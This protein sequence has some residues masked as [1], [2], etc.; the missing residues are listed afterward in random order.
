M[1]CLAPRKHGSS[2]SL[3]VELLSE[4]AGDSPTSPPHCEIPAQCLA[5]GGVEGQRFFR[6]DSEQIR[7]AI[8]ARA[9]TRMLWAS[10]ST[11]F[12]LLPLLQR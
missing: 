5:C 7:M 10:D 8:P 4:Q 1:S 2:G 12:L 11:H 9:P 6:V 3:A